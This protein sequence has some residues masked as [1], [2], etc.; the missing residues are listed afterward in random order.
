MPV[1]ENSYSPRSMFKIW[2]IVG[3]L[4]SL[5]FLMSM[6]VALDMSAREVQVQQERFQFQSAEIRGLIDER[7]LA[8][9][10]I[11]H[12]A[13]GLFAS[14]GAINRAQFAAYYDSLQVQQHYPGILALAF[15]AYIPA[16]QLQAH[17]DGVRAE[18]FPD[19][20]VSPPGER[21]VYTSIVYIE[22]FAGV[23]LNAFGY[24]MYSEAVRR[25]AMDRAAATGAHALSGKVAL[26]QDVDRSGV[27]GTLLYMPVYRHEIIPELPPST[28][29]YGWVYAPFSMDLLM[30][31]VRLDSF[32]SLEVTIYDG[33]TTAPE[34]MLYSTAAGV[35]RAHVPAFVNT[36]TVLIAGRPWT[37]DVRSTPAFE[38]MGITPLVVLV[39]GFSVSLLLG[40]LFWSLVTGRERA[41][42]LAADIT[43]ELS[44]TEFRFKAALAGAG[45]GVW[46]WNN[47]TDEVHYSSRWKSMLHYRND[48]IPNN[49]S[50]WKELVHPDDLD[51]VLQA[52]TDCLSG[53]TENLHHEMRMRT[54][55]GDWL[56]ILSRGAVVQ[57]DEQGRA[58]RSIGT[59]TDIS[60][61]KN[62]ELA[63]L[64]SDRR[65]RGA[66][67]NSAIGMALVDLNGDWLQIN[68][69][70]AQMLGYGMDDFKQLNARDVVHPDD[71]EADQQQRHLL[72]NGQQEYYQREERFLRQNGEVIYVQLS[73][74][75]VRDSA[76]MPLHYVAQIQDITERHQLQAL[77]EHQAH[78]DELTGLPNRRLM[79]DRLNQTIVQSR[80]YQRSMAVMFVDIDHFK[81]INDKFGH[82]VGDQV[83][84]MVA[85]RLRRCIRVSDTLARLG[86]DEFVVILSEIQNASDASRVAQAMATA[87]SAPLLLRMQEICVTLS[88]GIAIFQSAAADT[89][90]TLLKKADEALY[91]VKRAGRNGF[92]VH[93]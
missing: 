33:D 56:W 20:R 66:F 14:A 88:I 70:L 73:V 84:C 92:R 65:F 85:D 86:G 19:Y 78:H 12:G 54:R 29:L 80:R 23:N 89:D 91:E 5:F 34:A 75:L 15:A 45:D 2:L 40:A 72:K 79:S 28:E 57:R 51:S 60:K 22:P 37:I 36:E 6:L 44:K 71:W 16:E 30:Q 25:Q 35:E 1:S 26:V 67:E 49:L 9:E 42:V 10:Q 13:H 18:G 48:E 81:A 77:V 4:T 32:L 63:L 90:E 38:T 93:G 87:L 31:G 83:L 21:E 52:V 17:I 53:K 46:D 50:A 74:S 11:L 64:E 61:Q 3:L 41:L 68:Q 76:D 58:L 62:D 24:D 8:Y 82:D 39:F 47:V 69:A 59:H 55:D 43:R 7:M 27:A